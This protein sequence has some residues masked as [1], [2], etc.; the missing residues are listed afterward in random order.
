[1]SVHTLDNTESKDY[2]I[3]LTVQIPKMVYQ[4]F[5][6]NGHDKSSTKNVTCPD[7]VP[8]LAMAVAHMPV[9]LLYADDFTICKSC[10]LRENLYL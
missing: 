10:N 3:I 1:M 8:R 4:T 7:H 2:F 9:T 5:F 6:I